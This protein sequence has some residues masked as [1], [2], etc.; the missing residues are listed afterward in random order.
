M[1]LF[2]RSNL[3]PLD[4]LLNTGSPQLA[5]F[6]DSRPEGNILAKSTFVDNKSVQGVSAAWTPNGLDALL[7]SFKAHEGEKF[8]LSCRSESGLTLLGGGGQISAS[9][10]N[11]GKCGA[12]VTY[13]YD[14]NNTVPEPA[15]LALF[16]LAASTAC[17]AGRRRRV[18]G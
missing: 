17:V 7:A 10:T 3:S 13:T 18:K 14:N 6:A 12:S 15:S 11:R 2:Y 9:Q 5:L 1:D 16:G 8:T 4:A